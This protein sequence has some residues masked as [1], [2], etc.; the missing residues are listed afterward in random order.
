MIDFNTA[1]LSWIVVGACSLGGTGYITVST[2]IQEM[3]KKVEVTQ[4][5]TENMHDQL[6]L[7]QKQLDRIENSVNLARKDK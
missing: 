2:S 6:N 1:Q 5:R 7:M 4:V 3:D